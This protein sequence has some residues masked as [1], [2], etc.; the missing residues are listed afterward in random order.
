MSPEQG[1]KPDLS[2]LKPENVDAYLRTLDSTNTQDSSP[3]KRLLVIAFVFVL[4]MVI[5]AVIA[6][7]FSSSASR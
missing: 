7:Q 3:N 5:T 4:F 1:E 2:K 6:M